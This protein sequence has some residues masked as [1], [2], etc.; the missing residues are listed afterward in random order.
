MKV[1]NGSKKIFNLKS[2]TMSKIIRIGTRDSEIALWQANT[3]SQKLNDF[4]YKTIIV[5]VNSDGDIILDKLLYELG[6][7]GIFTKTLEVA[8]ISGKVD[9][10]VRSMKDIPTAMPQGIIQ[11]AVL[12]R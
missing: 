5:T 11:A 9:I 1:L 4:G 10:A 3:V 12:K 2:Y 6:I 8:M 7:T